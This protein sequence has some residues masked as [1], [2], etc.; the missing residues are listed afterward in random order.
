MWFAAFSSPRSHEWF[1]PLLVK[2]LEGD[3]ATL[4]LLAR[5]PFPGGPPPV[6]RAQ[7]W[8]Y[9]FTTAAERRESGAWWH[10]TYVRPYVPPVS[11]P[12]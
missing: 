12:R 6:V 1:M 10:R 11:L 5:D 8:L 3:R 7:L 4:R 2:L 9:R